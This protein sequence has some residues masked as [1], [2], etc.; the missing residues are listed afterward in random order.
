MASL[1]KKKMA[2]S[3]HAL[4]GAAVNFYL[5]VADHVPDEELIPYLI[6]YAHSSQHQLRSFYFKVI[7]AVANSV[8]I[9]TFIEGFGR[10][11]FALRRIGSCLSRSHFSPS[12]ANSGAFS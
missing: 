11:R 4:A 3:P 9:S 1:V 5:T 6:E 12:P 8:S 2:L 10:L 7:A